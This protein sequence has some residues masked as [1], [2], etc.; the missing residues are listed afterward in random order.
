MKL[1]LD[2]NQILNSVFVENSWS[3]AAIDLA[4]QHGT[5]LTTTHLAICEVEQRLSRIS[6]NWRTQPE[7]NLRLSGWM[8]DVLVSDDIH[9][10]SGKYRSAGSDEFLLEKASS[11]GA[12][13]L[14]SD[15]GLVVQAKSFGLEVLTPLGLLYSLDP[16]RRERWTGVPPSSRTAS[17]YLDGSFSPNPSDQLSS[18]FEVYPHYQV[19][20]SLGAE[21]RRLSL[22]RSD[23]TMVKGTAVN[24]NPVCELESEIKLRL[25]LGWHDKKLVFLTN[26]WPYRLETEHKNQVAPKSLHIGNRLDGV[27]GTIRLRSMITSD[28]PPPKLKVWRKWLDAGEFATPQPFD[29][30]RLASAVKEPLV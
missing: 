18:M 13:L 29:A 17:I 6:K 19:V 4:R 27:T 15:L 26:F 5:E 16:N 22:A 2:A 11:T 30:D 8:E 21:Q 7:V 23:K 1:L 25:L 20:V 12:I 3:R 10:T 24:I 28:R 14:S 9:P